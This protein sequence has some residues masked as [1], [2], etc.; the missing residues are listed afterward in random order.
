MNNTPNR[1]HI[2]KTLNG[3]WEVFDLAQNRS[4]ITA[5]HSEYSMEI[6]AEC[7]AVK[8]CSNR[9][10]EVTQLEWVDADKDVRDSM[11]DAYMD[12]A[13]RHYSRVQE[14]RMKALNDKP[15]LPI[16]RR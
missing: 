16:R 6:G 5:T 8:A 14:L 13:L 11:V 12:E 9:I 2:R 7:A 1:F 3:H 10:I 4:V 15:S